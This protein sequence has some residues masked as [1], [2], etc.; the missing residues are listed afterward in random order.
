ML[1][2]A[3]LLLLS[4]VSTSSARAQDP[5]PELVFQYPSEGATLN[6]PAFFLQLCFAEPI[7]KRDLVAG[8][9]FA[10][11]LLQPDGIAL[12][13]RDVFQFDAY[14][15]SIYPGLTVGEGTAGVWNFHW[16]VTSPDGE[17]SL[18]GDIAYTVDP[19]G[20][21]IPTATPP[22]CIGEA[23]TGTV[24]ATPEGNKPTDTPPP[25]SG[26]TSIPTSAATPTASPIIE[27]SDD[28]PD[29]DKYAYLTIGAAGAAAVVLTLG[30][31]FRR[32]IG[33]DPHKPPNNGDSGHH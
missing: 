9:D 26:A 24:T 32:R 19:E 2:L 20:D 33:F 12:G 18:E 17:T 23:G 10:F 1:P 8:G 21:P 6:A 16:R 31:L 30:Y 14:G 11:S 25:V 27:E 5:A 3:A 22:P 4:A 29:I 13:H 28:D 7:N 15:V